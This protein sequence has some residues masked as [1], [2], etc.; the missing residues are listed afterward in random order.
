[1]KGSVLE[2]NLSSLARSIFKLPRQVPAGI[3]G[4][5]PGIANI[6]SAW[7]SAMNAWQLHAVVT[8]LFYL[9]AGIVGGVLV[10]RHVVTLL[11]CSR[12]SNRNV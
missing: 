8:E 12:C 11:Q 6:G 3:F 7:Q 5:V 9:A 2:P 10:A 1:M 4:L